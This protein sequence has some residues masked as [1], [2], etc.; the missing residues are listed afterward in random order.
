MRTV[1]RFTVF[2]AVSLAVGCS[3]SD[4]TAPLIDDGAPIA[5]D[6][7]ALGV[8]A[9]TG[10]ST[11]ATAMLPPLPPEL[12]L[13]DAQRAQITQLIS[14]FQDAT[15]ADM[16]TLASIQRQAQEARKAGK[17]D[18]DTKAILSQGASARARIEVAQAKLRTDIE[19]VL[20]PAQLVWLRSHSPK[21]C[22]SAAVILTA[23]QQAQIKALVQAFERANKP[24]LIAVAQAM[25][26][27]RN[28]KKAGKTEAEIRVILQSVSA[29]Q[30]RLERAH[31]VLQA[32]IEAVLT[33]E[34]KASGCFTR[35]P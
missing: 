1:R 5:M 34:Q 30:A 18:A 22:S 4:A 24:D 19:A 21:V 32:Q 8:V 16:T 20:T 2:A 3:N 6:G 23:A 27:A 33:P 13:S 9:A 29:A 15:K 7:S 17:P 25:E 12:K 35:G 26:Q 31:R 14:A 10:G 11:G 28:A